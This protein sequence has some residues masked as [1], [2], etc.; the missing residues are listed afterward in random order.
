MNVVVSADASFHLHRDGKGQKVD[1]VLV[2]LEMVI[3]PMRIILGFRANTFRC[4]IID[5]KRTHQRRH[6]HRV[7]HLGRP[8][9]A[10]ARRVHQQ[11]YPARAGPLLDSDYSRAR[12]LIGGIF[13]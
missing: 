4:E 2:L 10:R 6:T 11:A 1:S 3:F 5:G 12:I 9:A 8:T 13:L 7:Q